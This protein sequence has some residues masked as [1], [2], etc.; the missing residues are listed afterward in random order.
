MLRECRGVGLHVVD[1][2]IIRRL[3]PFRGLPTNGVLG[4]PL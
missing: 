3:H 2:A 1:V 4:I